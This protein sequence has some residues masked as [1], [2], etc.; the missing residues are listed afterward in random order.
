MKERKDYSLG[1]GGTCDSLDA[2]PQSIVNG[3]SAI[4]H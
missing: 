1:M 2:F 3:L 4:L